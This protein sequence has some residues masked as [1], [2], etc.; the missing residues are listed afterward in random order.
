M[1]IRVV[2]NLVC[3]NELTVIKPREAIVRR[4]CKSPGQRVDPTTVPQST[5]QLPHYR[6][7]NRSFSPRRNILATRPTKAAGIQSP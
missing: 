4:L 2:P 5:H 6:Q 1:T 3:F 7:A